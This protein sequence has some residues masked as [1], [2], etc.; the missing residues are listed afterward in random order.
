MA[1][2]T[3]EALL[4]DYPFGFYAN[5][6]LG[7]ILTRMGNEE[8]ALAYYLRSI[9]SNPDY[10]QSRVD[11][12]LLQVNRGELDQ[13]IENLRAALPLLAKPEAQGLRSSAFYGLGAAYAN[14][15]DYRQAREMLDRSLE[16]MPS[17]ASAAG[18]RRQIAREER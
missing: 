10:P 14:K 18:L 4:E 17:N 7:S 12:G 11:L 16:A 15:G 1:E 2:T 9:V 5:Y 3:Y 13:A 8:G 6:L